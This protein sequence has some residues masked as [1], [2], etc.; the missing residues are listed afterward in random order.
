MDDLFPKPLSVNRFVRLRLI[1]NVTALV[2]VTNNTRKG[3][4]IVDETGEINQWHCFIM[5]AGKCVVVQIYLAVVWVV[6][7]NIISADVLWLLG[8]SNLNLCC[9]WKHPNG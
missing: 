4:E 2:Q 9:V 5:S 3:H 6:V 7:G 1:L 8:V